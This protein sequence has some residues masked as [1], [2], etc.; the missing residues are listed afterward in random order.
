MAV[1]LGLAGGGLTLYTLARALK[2]LLGGSY[3]RCGLFFALNVLS[4]GGTLLLCALRW[5]EKLGWCG[6]AMA[7]VLIA[8]GFANMLVQ[9]FRFQKKQ[10]QAAADAKKKEEKDGR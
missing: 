9:Q 2:H 6:G 8:G 1:L 7:A 5:P 10:R 3:G 4:M